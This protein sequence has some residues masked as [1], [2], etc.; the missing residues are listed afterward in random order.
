[1]IIAK[2]SINILVIE[3]KNF[4][5]IVKFHSFDLIPNEI[6][7]IFPLLT[8]ILIPHE[9]FYKNSYLN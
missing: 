2:Y 6:G 8:Y 1:M 7:L 4:V 3:C 9:I 5:N